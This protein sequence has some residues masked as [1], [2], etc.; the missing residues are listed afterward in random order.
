MRLKFPLLQLLL[1]GAPGLS[2]LVLGIDKHPINPLTSSLF[3]SSTVH[4]GRS[5][6]RDLRLFSTATRSSLSVASI[7]LKVC[8]LAALTDRGKLQD[9]LVSDEGLYAAERETMVS[10]LEL[11]IA[12]GR[13]RKQAMSPVLLEGEWELVYSTKQLFRSSPFFQAIERAYADPTKSE[14]FFKLHELQTCSWGASQ[15]GRVAQTIDLQA[16]TLLSSFDTVLFP[17]TTI[18]L[19]GKPPAPRLLRLLARPMPPFFPPFLPP[20]P[21]AG[22][23]SFLPSEAASIPSPTVPCALPSHP[24]RHHPPNPSCP[25]P[26]QLTVS[27]SSQG[28]ALRLEYAV[29]KTSFK[30]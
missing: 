11:L 13:E 28:T 24:S 16:Q 17:L 15:I 20:S 18:P 19:I 2:S 29:A 21:Q 14:L 10:L 1:L 9:P 27:E 30:R 25:V 5:T 7:K 8:Q 22:S 4:N 3:I 12:K 23:S 6:A 26:S